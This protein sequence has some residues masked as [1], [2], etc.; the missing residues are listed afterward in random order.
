V[1]LGDDG[2][3]RPRGSRG[4]RLPHRLGHATRMTERGVT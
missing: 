4:H 2:A 3:Q 1:V